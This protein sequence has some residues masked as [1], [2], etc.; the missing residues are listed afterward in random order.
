M[1]LITTIAIAFV[2]VAMGV[3]ALAI[4]WMITGKARIRGSC[5]GRRPDGKCGYCGKEDDKC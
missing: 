4:G 3:A 5:G 2:C 1:D